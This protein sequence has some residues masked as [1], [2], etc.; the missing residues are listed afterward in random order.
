MKKKLV[1]IMSLLNLYCVAQENLIPNGGFEDYVP[2]ILDNQDIQ[3][4]N[5]I[6]RDN[7][8]IPCK[9]G[10]FEV[11]TDGSYNVADW[12]SF[13]HLTHDSERWAPS[14]FDSR[15]DCDSPGNSDCINYCCDY[16]N[17]T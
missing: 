16:S 1:I 17:E 13:G 6:T 12:I 9:R 3:N 8:S 15:A 14:L 11:N 2:G 4:P 7:P 5:N 10:Y